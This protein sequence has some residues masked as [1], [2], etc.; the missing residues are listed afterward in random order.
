MI[1]DRE[2]MILGVDSVGGGSDAELLMRTFLLQ[3]GDCLEDVSCYL[4]FII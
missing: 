4:R 1:I 2:T 3:G